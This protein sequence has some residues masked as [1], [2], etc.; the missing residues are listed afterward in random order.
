[1]FH[2]STSD[3]ATVRAYQRMRQTRT[4]EAGKRQLRLLVLGGSEED[5]ASLRELFAGTANGP[6]RL[7]HAASPED[8][9][10]QLGKGSYDL[11]LCSNQSTDNVAFQVLRQV[12]QHVSGVPLIFLSDPVNTDVIEVAI[13]TIAGHHAAPSQF[14]DAYATH[15][16]A[17]DAHSAERQ[18]LQ[19]E[20]IL[21]KLWRSV[22]QMADALTIMDGSGVMEYVNPAFEALTGY[23]RQE[24]IGQTLGILKS[25]QQASDLYEEMWNTVRSGNVFRGIMMNR[26]KNGET[27]I[28]E[29]VLTP[30][31]DGSGEIT[32]FIST[33]RDITE[34]RRLESELQQ[35]QKMDAIGRLAG[36]VAHDF[37]NLLLVI[38]AY[39]ELML[40]SLAAEDPLRRNVAEIMTASRRAADL[41]RQLLAFG[42]KQMQLL[43][44]LDLNTVIGEI[45]TM[46]PRLIG[47]DVELVF[48]PAHDLGKVKADPIQIEQVV[49]NL[50]ANARDAMPGGGTLTIET[51]SVRVDEFYVQRHSIV[52]AGDYVLLTVTDSGQGIA[53]EDMAHIFEPFYTTKEAGKGTGLGLATV[54]GIVKQNGGFV[55]VYSEPGLGTTFKVYLPQVQSLSNEIVITKAAESSPRGCETLLL[56]EDE[57]S[58]RQAARQFLTRS[59][60]NVLEAIDGEDAL[61]ASREYGGP[62]QLMITD[63]VMPRL[64]GP[65]LAERLADERPDMKVLF[66][67]GYAEN[68]IL[69]HG[70]IDVRTRFL[71]KPFSLKTLAR[72]VREVLEANETSALAASSRGSRGSG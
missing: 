36:G 61:R 63:V 23:S 18:H 16:I 39:A 13:Q 70:K 7:E 40:D 64:G 59:G 46:L 42:R 5:F 47:E 30:L 1:M 20:E 10:N 69:Q 3:E 72:K 27:L 4:S 51:A 11:L 71:Q 44:V 58:V 25:E 17:F 9:L 32:H 52:P 26:K 49:M 66:V 31:R 19:S 67:S 48:A 8:V 28:I 37:N 57:A 56:V 34:R 65:R 62:I 53:A 24:A 15:A 38:S 35:S 60:Y 54:Y 29:K 6:L 14:R 21:R 2:G 55:W 68:T 22:E 12:R 50:A 45:T 43:Q 41:T 33:F